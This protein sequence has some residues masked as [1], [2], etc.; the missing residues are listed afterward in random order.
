MK[1]I[2]TFSLLLVLLIN[3]KAQDSVLLNPKWK[4]YFARTENSKYAMTTSSQFDQIFKY[5]EYYDGL[6]IYRDSTRTSEEVRIMYKGIVDLCSK[7]AD[8]E[9]GKWEHGKMRTLL[10][11]NKRELKM[12]VFH[13]ITFILEVT[14]KDYKWVNASPQTWSLLIL[15]GPILITRHFY[16]SSATSNGQRILEDSAIQKYEESLASSLDTFGGFNFKKAMSTAVAENTEMVGKVQSGIEG[17]TKK[18]ALKIFIEYNEWVK[19]H[20]NEKFIESLKLPKIRRG[21]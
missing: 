9:I 18:D 12:F 15:N 19:Q 14:R 5:G 2:T 13:D 3:G 11:R 21:S 6:L 8:L 4:D 1:T 10:G 20:D 17:Y 16:L 7:L